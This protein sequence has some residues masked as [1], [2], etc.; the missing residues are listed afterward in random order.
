MTGPCVDCGQPTGRATWARCGECHR[1]RRDVDRET[2]ELVR[3]FLLGW[4]SAGQTPDGPAIRRA[5]DR[6]LA[7]REGGAS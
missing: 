1:R 4:A 2:R 6:V 7:K 3:W 5:L